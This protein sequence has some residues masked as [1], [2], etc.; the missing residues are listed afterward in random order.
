MLQYNSN[1]QQTLVKDALSTTSG[2]MFYDVKYS[3]KHH[4]AA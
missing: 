3:I 1:I 4:L 2:K